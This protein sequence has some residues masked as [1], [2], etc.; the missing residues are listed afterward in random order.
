MRQARHKLAEREL[1][2]AGGACAPTSLVRRCARA[3]AARTN[4]RRAVK[5]LHAHRPHGHEHLSAPA[6]GSSAV[7]SWWTGA[8]ADTRVGTLQRPRRRRQ[9]KRALRG[10]S[11]RVGAPKLPPVCTIG[12]VGGFPH[13]KYPRIISP[14]GC[15]HLVLSQSTPQ[16]ERPQLNTIRHGVIW[17]DPWSR[18]RDHSTY[19]LENLQSARVFLSCTDADAAYRSAGLNR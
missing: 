13:E 17:L 2:R 16:S 8:R 14:D 1:V 7:C 18:E 9:E 10:R 15:K 11:G 19:T 5:L 3:L 6:N 4:R 12:E